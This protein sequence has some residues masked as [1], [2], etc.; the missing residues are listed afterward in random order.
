M[1]VHLYVK[2]LSFIFVGENGYQLMLPFIV[3][4]RERLLANPE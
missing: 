2:V 4:K 3:Y 1:S